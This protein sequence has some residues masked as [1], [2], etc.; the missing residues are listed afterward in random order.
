MGAVSGLLGVGGGQ[1]GTGIQGPQAAD[2]TSPVTQQQ[3]LDA[4][5]R[6]QGQLNNQNTLL[7]ALQGQNGIQNQSNVFN[8]LQNVANGQGPNPAQAMLN[9]QTGQNV[10]NQAALMAGQRGAG[11]NV[12]LLARQAAMQGAATQQQAVGQG[13]TMQA[14]QSLGALNQLGGI[15][16]QQVGQQIAQ[17]QNNNQAAQ[18]EQQALLGSLGNYQA[19]ITSNQNNINSANAALANTTMQGQQGLIGGGLN[20]A[21]ASFKAEGGPVEMADGGDSDA[22]N[23]PSQPQSFLGKFAKGY[24]DYN[25]PSANGASAYDYGNPGANQL[26]QGMGAWG[27]AFKS[28]PAS[29][30]IVGGNGVSKPLAYQAQGG[31]AHDYRSGGN[32]KAKSSNEKAVVHGNNYA[33]DKIPAMLSE[34][35]VVIPRNVMQSKDPVSASAKFVQAVMQ[36]RKMRG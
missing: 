23:D 25:K 14:Q 22:A 26:A 9:Q 24:S 12:G 13:A 6:S 8:Q 16:G 17:T 1:S 28:S 21:A 27:N 32:V 4:Y 34:G 36:K 20:A 35:E 2:I 5:N 11:A 18:N 7:Q 10:A 19:N 15:A 3:A 29:T 31:M 33:N 30:P